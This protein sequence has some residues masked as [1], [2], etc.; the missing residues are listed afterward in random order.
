MKKQMLKV[1]G[2]IA[3][4]VLSG[5]LLIT[6]LNHFDSSINPSTMELLK[7][8]TSEDELSLRECASLLGLAVSPDLHFQDEGERLLMLIETHQDYQ[9]PKDI[10][11]NLAG[12]PSCKGLC[13]ISATKAA[14]MRKRLA[15]K[16][17]YLERLQGLLDFQGAQCRNPLA[18]QEIPLQAL[19]KIT[20]WQLME[21]SVFV[22]EGRADK[23]FLGLKKMN[24]F[25]LNSLER[26][27]LS[28]MQSLTYVT[29][30]QKVRESMLEL[31]KKNAQ[32][33]K[34]LAK[35][36]SEFYRPLSF[37]EISRRT[38]IGE[39][40]ILA[41][42]LKSEQKLKELKSSLAS[43]Q[44][45]AAKQTA[46][47]F[48][49]E[50]LLSFMFLPKSTL[51]EAHRIFSGAAAH[52]CVRSD[53]KSCSSSD[54]NPVNYFHNPAGKLLI[55]TSMTKNTLERLKKLNQRISKVPN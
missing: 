12:I 7:R 38:E 55:D 18:L 32:F 19:L 48:S 24:A 31:T 52:P 49:F 13:Q 20:R 2:I 11:G 8:A 34:A 3:F 29:L 40:Q 27:K 39:M 17:I 21:Y 33:R 9:I 46:S 25:F 23:A 15:T 41:E 30:L 44:S 37:Q 1:A 4:G 26:E 45:Q 50:K 54:R 14:D 22:A 16:R 53:N 36:Q 42:K 5:P 51:N 28:M 35:K 6:I 47:S 43:Q 10:E